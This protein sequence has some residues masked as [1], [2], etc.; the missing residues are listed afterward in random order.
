M[1]RH[2]STTDR[3]VVLI[4]ITEAGEQ[5][6]ARLDDPMRAVNDRVLGHLER[7]DLAEL[8]RLLEAARDGE[9]DVS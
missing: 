6:L 1:L 9:A 3:R 7:N 5:L 4:A 8:N 2:R